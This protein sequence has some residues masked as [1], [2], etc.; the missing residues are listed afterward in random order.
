MA[1][2]LNSTSMLQHLENGGNLRLNHHNQVVAQNSF[3]HAVQKLSDSIASLSGFGR[4]HIEKRNHALHTAM[5]QL[6]A[7]ADTDTRQV[8]PAEQSIPNKVTGSQINLMASRVAVGRFMSEQGLTG[9][10][11]RPL[12]RYLS[13]QL[14]EKLCAGKVEQKNLRQEAAALYGKISQNSELASLLTD[15]GVEFNAEEQ[16]FFRDGMQKELENS[17]PSQLQYTDAATGIHE[18]YL[19]D[20]AR[21]SLRSLQGHP[22]LGGDFAGQ[23]DLYRALSDELSK[24]MAP[25]DRKYTQLLSTLP[26]QAGLEGSINMMFKAG[27]GSTCYNGFRYM[28]TGKLADHLSGRHSDINIGSDSITV[29]TEATMRLYYLQDI[30]PYSTNYVQEQITAHKVK[31][32]VEIPLNQDLSGKQ[33][34]DFRVTDF[35]MER[36]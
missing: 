35:S 30:V 18:N 7:E 36:I 29:D 17:L 16:Q 1:V 21:G 15:M 31:V 23:T 6:L 32:R 34:P 3:R 12:Q 11:N 14:A 28:P 24:L 2:V 25:Y 26:T 9:A 4:A 13:F 22:P 33:L 10:E 20:V 27:L 19:R 5:A 8:N